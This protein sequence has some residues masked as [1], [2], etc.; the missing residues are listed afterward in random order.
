L[1]FA[2]RCAKRT[3]KSHMACSNASRSAWL[4]YRQRSRRRRQTLDTTV[5]SRIVGT[6]SYL[7]HQVV[8]NAELAKRVDTSDEWIYTRTGIR[9]RHIAAEEERTSDLALAAAREAL[10]AAQIAP[11]D[12]DL[13]VLATTTPDM[14]FPSTACILQAKLGARNGP[15]LDVQ[16]VCSGFVSALATAGAMRRS[17]RARNA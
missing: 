16:A 14:I 2:M 9:Q 7:P 6:G 15:A 11:Q 8:T 13:I 4:Q 1:R 10:A 5:R 12:V 17:R 3:P